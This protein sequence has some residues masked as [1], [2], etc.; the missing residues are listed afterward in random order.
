MSYY[1][2]INYW[3][4]GGFDGSKSATAAIDD[5]KTLGLDGLELTYGDCLKPGLS[6]AECLSIVRHAARQRVGLRTLASG[7]Y[8]TC[9]LSSPDPKERQQAVEFSKQ[10]LKTAAALGVETVLI[11]PGA[12]D[13]AWDPSRPVVPYDLVW[14]HS[15]ASIRKLVKLAERLK[16][17]LAL[18][19]VWN[20]FLLSP[21]E[22]KFYLQQFDSP[23]VGI[24]LDTGNMAIN[25]YAE[26]WFGILGKRV[27]A[28]HVKNFK[29]NDDAGGGLHGFGEDLAVG[30]VNFPAIKQAMVAARYRG[31]LTA[32]MIPFSRLPHLNIP[33]MTLARK[34]AKILKQLF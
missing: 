3:V 29:R 6:S 33:D 16:V 26:H 20:K 18:E 11:V 4:L 14:K 30:D 15:V 31:P 25:G 19:N 8:W 28:V 13:V 24:Y 23:R 2:A 12:V 5:V 9:S 10:Y 22:W 34:T 1:K 32:E 27:K 7:H 21:M 17:N